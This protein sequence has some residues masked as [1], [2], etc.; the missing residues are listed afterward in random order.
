[1]VER[2]ADLNFD[3]NSATLEINTVEDLPSGWSYNVAVVL[4]DGDKEIIY[5]DSK[6]SPQYY[7]CWC[8]FS[9]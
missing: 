9:F 5:F 8:M 6:K 1:M 3:L 4:N 2:G 7:L